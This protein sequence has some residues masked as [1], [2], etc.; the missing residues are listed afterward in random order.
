MGDTLRGIGV[1][2]SAQLVSR[3]VTFLLNVLIAR[4][5]APSSYGI[6]HVSFQLFSNLSLFLTKEGFRKVALRTQLNEDIGAETKPGEGAAL[7]SAVN[8]GWCGALCALLVTLPL[9]GYWAYTK[10][11]GAPPSYVVAV[12]LMSFAS[13]VEAF[14]E[15]FVV[16]ALL[17]FD[18]GCRAWGEAAAMLSRTALMFALTAGTGD[19]PLAFAA[20]QLLYGAVWAVWFA[21]R[22]GGA[23]WPARGPGGELVLPQQRAL[24][25]E[26]AGMAALKLA[27]TEGETLLLLALFG[28]RDWGVFGLVSNFGSIILRLLFAPTEEV[29][30][31][32]FAEP[33]PPERQ[34]AL[35]RS[36]LVLQGGVGWLG[37]CFGPGFAELVIRILYGPEWAA[38]QAS[39]VLAA[40]CVLLFCMAINGIM[41]AFMYA[42]CK[43]SWVSTCKRAQFAIWLALMG[44]AWLGRPHGPIALVWAN[45]AAMVGRVLLC[46]VFVRGHLELSWAQ[47]CLGP[48]L[49]IMVLLALAGAAASCVV[50]RL[51]AAAAI[52]LATG[53]I[54]AVAA[55]CRRELQAAVAVVRSH[56]AD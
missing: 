48:V 21:R 53:S 31:R 6:S 23:R 14:A 20:S 35:L 18:F 47:L 39:S 49:Q 54:M 33:A 8:L 34:W 40:Y 28:E 50:P 12:A 19:L 17:A 55:F 25:A 29:A 22:S 13:I 43:P 2:A 42:Q 51:V 15:P 44:A 16:G 4:F 38:S 10:P 26:F 36:L 7:R 1:I 9:A 24:L 5:A 46:A 32:A 45:C 41:E 37:A 27:L 11:V 3:A 52:A 30:F 56:R